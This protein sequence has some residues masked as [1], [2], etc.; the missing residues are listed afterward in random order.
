MKAVAVSTFL[1]VASLLTGAERTLGP[2]TL[3]LADDVRIETSNEVLL[4]FIGGK[5]GVPK[6]HFNVQIA[7]LAKIRSGEVS[8]P[9]GFGDLERVLRKKKK[10]S[11]VSPNGHQIER[12]QGSMPIDGRE[13][14][15]YAVVFTGKNYQIYFALLDQRGHSEAKSLFD[16][17]FGQIDRSVL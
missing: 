12:L 11:T 9:D 15:A 1:V 6:A 2:I 8:V 5:S 4:A 17:I 3:H 7:E 13:A 14:F 16:E 10:A